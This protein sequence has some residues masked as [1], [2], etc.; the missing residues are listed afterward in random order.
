MSIGIDRLHIMEDLINHKV[1]I[2]EVHM[3]IVAIMI[4]LQIHVLIEM[5]KE[6]VMPQIRLMARKANMT[7][8]SQQTRAF[9]SKKRSKTRELREHA[10]R[11]MNLV[12]I[13]T[14]KIAGNQKGLQ[15]HVL[16]RIKM[17]MVFQVTEKTLEVWNGNST[18][19]RM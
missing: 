2:I 17:Q 11:R 9:M 4:V 6:I 8:I 5:W 18:V 14:S 13:W 16:R 15:T 19:E 3:A 10:L 7:Q 1:G 12:K